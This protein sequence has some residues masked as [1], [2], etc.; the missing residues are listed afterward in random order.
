MTTVASATEY[1]VA[2]APPIVVDV[3]ADVGNARTVGWCGSDAADA[4]IVVARPACAS[5][6]AHFPTSCCGARSAG[7]VVG[8]LGRDEHVIELVASSGSGQP[9]SSTRARSSGRG[10]DQR[11]LDGTT[12]DLAGRRGGGTAAGAARINVR[13][14]NHAADQPLAD[15]RSRGR[16]TRGRYPIRY[17]GRDL[18][19]TVATV[20]VKREAEAAFVGWT[21][22]R[23]GRCDRRRR[24]IP[25]RQRCAVQQWPVPLGPHR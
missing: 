14:T 25:H 16:G 15:G 21:V 2:D 20:A 1:V 17:N 8:R 19:V 23:R 10:S 13:L 7:G 11:Y 18:V 22:T 4:P 5:S 24:R 12:L 3:V 6:T 9:P